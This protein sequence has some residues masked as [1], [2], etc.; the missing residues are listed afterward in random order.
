MKMKPHIDI[1]NN[2]L[3]AGETEHQR[4]WLKF[5]L[6]IELTK[7]TVGIVDLVLDSEY[8]G[9]L[10]VLDSNGNLKDIQV[11]DCGNLNKSLVSPNCSKCY[12]KDIPSP[13]PNVCARGRLPQFCNSFLYKVCIDGKA[14]TPKRFYDRYDV[15]MFTYCSKCQETLE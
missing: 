9:I 12:Y 11:A 13:Y 15:L 4:F 14:H 8:R 10:T 2:T 3:E 1:D 5:P 7:D 6:V